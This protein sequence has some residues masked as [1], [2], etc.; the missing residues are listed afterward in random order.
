MTDMRAIALPLCCL[1]A[2]AE[3]SAGDIAD[4]DTGRARYQMRQRLDDLR[5]IEQMTLAGRLE[6]A[7]PLAFFLIGRSDAVRDQAEDR[8][9]TLA[10][11]DL[12]KATTQREVLDAE[13]RI[14][15]ACA[16]CHER[17]RVS[18][19]FRASFNAPLDGLDVSSQMQRQ[20]WGLDRLFNGVIGPDDEQ[21]RAGLYVFATS[22]LPQLAVDN[23]DAARELR[24][25]ASQVIERRDRLTIEERTAVYRAV[26]GDCL[27]CH[28]HD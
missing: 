13:M 2:C 26:L 10:A 6:P 19:A 4:D 12:M 24:L 15:S 1:A 20:Q 18:R 17:Q 27:Q 25:R 14:A 28:A 11:S 21:W 7:K 3:A 5:T 16:T 22:P 23:T 8:E 9:I